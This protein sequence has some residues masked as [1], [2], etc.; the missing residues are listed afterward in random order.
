[1]FTNSRITCLIIIAFHPA[2]PRPIPPPCPSHRVPP[3]LVPS[4]LCPSHP[5]PIRLLVSPALVLCPVVL[6]V[7]GRGRG[8]LRLF[9]S[10]PFSWPQDLEVHPRVAPCPAD[11]LPPPPVAVLGRGGRNAAGPSQ[12]EGLPE[13]GQKSGQS[14]AGPGEFLWLVCSTVWRYDTGTRMLSAARRRFL[15]V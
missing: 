15:W 12:V 1:M 3:R 13:S 4:C 7:P 5:I 10:G 11:D 8:A 9:P 14:C 6:Y 2:P